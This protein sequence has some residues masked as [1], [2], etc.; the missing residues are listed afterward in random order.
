[1]DLSRY[2]VPQTFMTWTLHGNVMCDLPEEELA[3]YLRWLE[4]AEARAAE[5]SRGSRS[6]AV[7][8]VPHAPDPEFVPAAA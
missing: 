6:R 5:R 1:M 3:E 7:R 2:L 8:A 4:A